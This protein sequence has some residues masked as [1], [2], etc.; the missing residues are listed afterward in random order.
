[1][2]GN[3][4]NFQPATTL[5]MLIQFKKFKVVCN[6]NDKI[7]LLMKFLVFCSWSDK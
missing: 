7:S 4:V 1:M 3:T 5:R 6:Q 2:N